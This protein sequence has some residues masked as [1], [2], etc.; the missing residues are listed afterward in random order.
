VGNQF[1]PWPQAG[2]SPPG[3][4]DFNQYE[5][6]QRED[7]RYQ[8]GFLGHDDI[9]DY[10]KPYVEFGWMDDRTQAVV[11]P[12]GLFRS[13]YPFTPD[14]NELINC[15]NPLLSPQQQAL[16]CTPA[17]IAGDT[18]NPGSKGNSA[19]VEIG[20]RNIEGGGRT[21]IYEHQNF[22][23]VVG[24]T[25]DVIDGWTY[26]AYASYYYVNT[27]QAN[28]NYLSYGNAGNALQVTTNALGQPVCISGGVCVPWN[29]FKTGGVTQAAL[30]YLDTPG[31]ASGNN[32]EQI[33]HIDLT[34]DLSKYGIKSPVAIDGVAINAGGEH[35]MDSVTFSPTRRSSRATWPAFPGRRYR[36]MRI[37]TSTR[38]S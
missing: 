25:G 11:A 3:V 26:D 23:L 22:R 36:S 27:F 9:N 30:N 37:T 17:Q 34:G 21:S 20:R 18:A 1:L 12:S 6:L 24:T 19:D 31:T 14:N 7:K 10:V 29:I 32:T 13:G 16:I 15:S 8:A 2:S 33:E 5:Y 4:Y 28:N 35:R 38:R